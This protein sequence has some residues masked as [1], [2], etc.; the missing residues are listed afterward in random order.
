MPVSGLMRSWAAQAMSLV[1]S[2]LMRFISSLRW[3][4]VSNAMA[5]SSHRFCFSL[6]VSPSGR[7]LVSMMHKVPSLW[8]SGA[9]SGTPGETRVN[10]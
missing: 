9:V 6:S 2:S 7:G 3:T 8:P 5:V 4:M 1:F 10:M